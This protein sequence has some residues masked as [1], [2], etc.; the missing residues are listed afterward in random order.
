MKL[1]NPAE[2]FAP[3]SLSTNRNASKTSRRP[4]IYHMICVPR[5]NGFVVG[6]LYESIELVPFLSLKL[7]GHYTSNVI[8]NSLKQ[9]IQFGLWTPSKKVAGPSEVSTKEGSTACDWIL[10]WDPLS[11]S[12]DLG[13]MGKGLVVASQTQ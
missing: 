10:K 13:L 7:Q 9:Q 1:V 5:N 2:G 6:E 8:D 12:E 3:S 11:N 4:E